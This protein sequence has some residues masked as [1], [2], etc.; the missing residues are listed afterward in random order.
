MFIVQYISIKA[1]FWNLY[2]INIQN[3]ILDSRREKSLVK[4]FQIKKLETSNDL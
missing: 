4:W 3:S 2:V 1:L